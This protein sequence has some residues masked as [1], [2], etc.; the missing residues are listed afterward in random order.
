MFISFHLCVVVKL[1]YTVCDDLF[2]GNHTY[3]DSLMGDSGVPSLDDLVEDVEE[4]Q[5]EE[6]EGEE[7]EEEEGGEG[8]MFG[9]AYW[10][11]LL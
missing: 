2:G 10:I 11:A 5:E 9:T 1:R 8:L 3:L 7:E 4:E 6:G